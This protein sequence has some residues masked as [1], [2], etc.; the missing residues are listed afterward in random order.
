MSL[1]FVYWWSRGL[2]DGVPAAGHFRTGCLAYAGRGCIVMSR[3]RMQSPICAELKFWALR[4]GCA[5]QHIIPCRRGSY[6]AT[7]V[8]GGE[9]SR[10][11][12]LSRAGFAPVRRRARSIEAAHSR[13]HLSSSRRGRRAAAAAPVLVAPVKRRLPSRTASP[14]RSAAQCTTASPNRRGPRDDDKRISITC[15]C[16]MNARVVIFLAKLI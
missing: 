14:C 1:S 3:R 9:F 13:R 11:A 7:R 15:A 10:A 2:P 16:H 5:D 4:A 6:V 8:C 12:P